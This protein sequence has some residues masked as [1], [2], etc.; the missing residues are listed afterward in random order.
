[1]IGSRPIEILR[2]YVDQAW[3]GSGLAAALMTCCEDLRRDVAEATSCG[4][5]LGRKQGRALAFY[6]KAGFEVVGTTQFRSERA[7]MTITFSRSASDG[8]ASHAVGP[9]QRA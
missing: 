1:M 7:S 6:R 8:R 9:K 4:C 3:H 2:F 5:R